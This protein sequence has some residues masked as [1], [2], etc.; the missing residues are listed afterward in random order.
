[1][2]VSV[3]KEKSAD[4]DDLWVNHDLDQIMMNLPEDMKTASTSANFS[5]DSYSNDELDDIMRGYLA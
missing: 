1:V 5:D 4:S 2:R 3:D